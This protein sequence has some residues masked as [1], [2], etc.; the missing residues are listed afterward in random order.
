MI[1][2]RQPWSQLKKKIG[3]ASDKNNYRS[4]AL[5]TVASKLF[6]ICILAVL[7]MCLIIH[8]KQSKHSSDMCVSKLKSVI[9]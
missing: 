9:K 4:I 7:G 2:L 6:E 3:D 8:D 5:F 1:L